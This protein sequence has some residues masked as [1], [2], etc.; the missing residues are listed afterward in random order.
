MTSDSEP[1]LNVSKSNEAVNDTEEHDTVEE[2]DDTTNQIGCPTCHDF[3]WLLH[4]RASETKEPKSEDSPDK[5][6]LESEKFI[7]RDTQNCASC[8][9]ISKAIEFCEDEWGRFGGWQSVDGNGTVLQVVYSTGEKTVDSVTF[10]FCLGEYLG[11]VC[12]SKC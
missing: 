5:W 4:T 12:E 2:E 9:V 7:S 11:V 10:D 6:S 3:C 1:T 8:A